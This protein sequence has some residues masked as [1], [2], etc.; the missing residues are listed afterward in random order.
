[1]PPDHKRM[2]VA[3]VVSQLL[4]VDSVGFSVYLWNNRNSLEIAKALNG[5]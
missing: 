3:E 5:R 1:M 2:L 4:D